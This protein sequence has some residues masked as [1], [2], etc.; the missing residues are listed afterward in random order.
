MKTDLNR[1]IASVDDAK[2]FLIDLF[3]N[4]ESYHPED[5]AFDIIWDDIEPSKA[6]LEELDN[7][8]AAV[9][10]YASPD[11]DPCE[12]LNNLREDYVQENTYVSVDGG[13]AMNLKALAIDEQVA[14]ALAEDD[15]YYIS[16]TAIEVPYP[17]G[18]FQIVRVEDP[19]NLTPTDIVKQI[20]AKFNDNFLPMDAKRVLGGFMDC[21]WQILVNGSMEGKEVAFTAVIDSGYYKLALADSKGGYFKTE[22]CFSLKT[23]DQCM[24][25]CRQLN[26]IVF[27]HTSERANEIVRLSLSNNHCKN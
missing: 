10:V 1:T 3:N 12:L 9:Y 19:N 4:G 20:T 7:L 24:E 5:S 16:K 11:F 8:M 22:V 27:E 14:P 26:S 21:L 6:Q 2:Q 13:K 25:S 23:Y 18:K 17:V 15:L